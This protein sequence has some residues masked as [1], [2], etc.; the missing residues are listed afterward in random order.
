MTLLEGLDLSLEVLIATLSQAI[1]SE[2]MG[3]ITTIASLPYDLEEMDLRSQ[4][5]KTKS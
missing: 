2:D 1:W 5:R 4:L 3:R